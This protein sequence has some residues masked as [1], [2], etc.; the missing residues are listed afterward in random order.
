ME[1]NFRTRMHSSSMHTT[2]SSS[3]QGVVSTRPSLDHDCIRIIKV[4]IFQ[5]MGSS[6]VVRH[7]RQEVSSTVSPMVESSSPVRGKVFVEFFFSNT[8]LAD[9]TE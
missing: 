7:E 6:T 8:I 2:R 3:R 1:T 5:E 4:S 9:L